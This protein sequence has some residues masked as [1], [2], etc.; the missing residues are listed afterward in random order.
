MKYSVCV[1]VR[2]SKLV[3]M[4]TVDAQGRAGAH[5]R[6]SVC[7]YEYTSARVVLDIRLQLSIHA[8]TLSVMHGIEHYHWMML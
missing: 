1:A 4:H 6:R 7:T 3:Y 2:A 8:Y 5:V